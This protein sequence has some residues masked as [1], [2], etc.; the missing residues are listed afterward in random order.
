M[1]EARAETGCGGLRDS[2][3]QGGVTEAGRRLAGVLGSAGSRCGSGGQAR[4]RVASPRETVVA[5]WHVQLFSKRRGFFP[6]KESKQ[7]AC[8]QAGRFGFLTRAAA[9]S[10]Q[11]HKFVEGNGQPDLFLCPWLGIL[12][13]GHS[14]GLRSSALDSFSAG[15]QALSPTVL[16]QSLP[17]LPSR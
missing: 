11:T 8:S 14:G 15:P 1:R 10:Q 6:S 7:L 12:G 3:E 13:P 16:P 5:P 9:R 17:S 2:A 4:A